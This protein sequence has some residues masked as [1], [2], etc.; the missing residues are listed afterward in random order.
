[1]FWT[2]TV[3]HVWRPF[4]PYLAFIAV[5]LIMTS[6]ADDGS[7]ERATSKDEGEFGTGDDG[8]S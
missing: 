5:A 7:D 3:E 2:D 8:R 1:M 4:L 6:R